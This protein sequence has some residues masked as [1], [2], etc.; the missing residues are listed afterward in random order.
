MSSPLLKN[1]D[2]MFAGATRMAFFAGQRLSSD[3]LNGVEDRNRNLRFLHN[4]GL[5]GWGVALGFDVMGA[6]GDTLVVVQPG[7]AIDSLGRELLLPDTFSVPVPS[8]AADPQGKAVTFYL[9]AAYRDDSAATVVERRAGDCGTDGAVRLNETAKVYWT[10]AAD[11]QGLEVILATAKVRNCRLDAPLSVDHRRSA[12][13]SGQPYVAADETP[14]PGTA[15]SVW[16]ETAAGQSVIVGV[17]TAVNTSAA[18]FGAT[19]HYLAEL[20]GPRFFR[21][22]DLTGFLNPA[23]ALPDFLFI[24]GT[25]IVVKPGRDGFEFHVLISGRDLIALFTT[26]PVGLIALLTANWRVSWT[27][28]EM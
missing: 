5:H 20:R 1:T 18:A 11:G 12:R 21:K 28:V 17:L 4:R 10:A 2:P 27:G 13:P 8:V 19:P 16:S 23:D 25:G 14:D 6:A 9:V 26:D 7:Y 3:D 24:D 15:W 22:S